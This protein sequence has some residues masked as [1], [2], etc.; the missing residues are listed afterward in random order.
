MTCNNCKGKVKEALTSVDGVESVVVDLNKGEATVEMNR[1]IPEE[2]LQAKL[3]D[4]YGLAYKVND[5]E[6]M[7]EVENEKSKL[8]QLKPLFLILGYILV[9]S[10]LLQYKNWDATEF[11]L[12]F[13][14]LFFIVF[15]F[16]K[17]LDLEGFSSTFRMYD[18]IAKRL[19]F[20]GKF[21]PLIETVLG[22]M[23]L[24]RWNV[25][26]PIIASIVILSFTT[27]GVT[28]TLLSKRK[29][30]CAC[31]GTVLN[32]PMTEATFIENAIMILM[33]AMLLFQV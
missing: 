22:L 16:F 3:P 10:I 23:F 28:R 26:I 1:M 20:Y 15:S 25:K 6:H 14:G 30:K 27:F 4:K 5:P 32:L 11:M 21:Y 8:E 24:M 18:P 31:L 12:D 17:F 13:M 19:P 9:A 2:M 33:A 7:V 29:I